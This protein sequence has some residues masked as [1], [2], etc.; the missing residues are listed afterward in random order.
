MS[1]VQISLL[2]CYIFIKTLSF[3]DIVDENMRNMKKKRDSSDETVIHW[4]IFCYEFQCKSEYPAV[5]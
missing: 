3:L 4:W 5:L 2:L 1:G